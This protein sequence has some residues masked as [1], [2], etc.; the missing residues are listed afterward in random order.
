MKITAS[1]LRHRPNT[2]RQ[3]C[4]VAPTYSGSVV[5][6][7]SGSARRNQMTT[8]PI[9]APNRNG[10]RQAQSVIAAVPSHNVTRKGT[11][12]P[13]ITPTLT[14]LEMIPAARPERW[15]GMIST[16]YAV[17]SGASTPV[18]MP[19]ARR[20][21]SRMT[22]AS[23]PMVLTSGITPMISVVTAM[24][25][26]DHNMTARRPTLS[27]TPPSR[28]PPSGRAM[29]PTANTDRAARVAST[30]LSVRKK[31]T[32]IV[33]ASRPKTCQSYHSRVLPSPSP[34]IDRR[35]PAAWVSASSNRC[36]S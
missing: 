18:E 15:V 6:R 2:W 27:A 19:C 5:C 33:A 21:R 20:Q 29:N 24:I 25:P 11:N 14:K 16:P 8:T 34:S 22:G 10:I 7:V 9:A 12:E 1:T 26:T 13:S 32:P 30:G 4:E 28:M 36:A 23:Q 3:I 35:S 31:W 17:D